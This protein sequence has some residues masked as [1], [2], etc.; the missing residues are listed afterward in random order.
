MNGIGRAILGVFALAGCQAAPPQAPG[1]EQARYL[2]VTPR[3]PTL[4]CSFTIDR[5][6]GGWTITSLTGALAITARYDAADRLVDAAARLGTGEPARVEVSGGR[7]K[8]LQP[9]REAQ[10]FDVPAGVIVTSAPDWTDTFRICRLWSGARGGR[11]EFPGLWIHPEKAGQRL[12]FTAER[13]GV[14]GIESG[15][16]KLALERLSIRLRGNSAYV[17]WVDP[18]GRMIKLVSL[19]FDGGS[20]VLVLEGFEGAAAALRPD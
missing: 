9:G 10:E 3:G 5:R 15:A 12:A 7:A 19:P 11:Q 20:T 2:R 14:D 1:P 17:A 13:A 18:Q 16:G 4:E 8:V 6:E